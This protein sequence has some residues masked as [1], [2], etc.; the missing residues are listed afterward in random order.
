MSPQGADGIANLNGSPLFIGFR[1]PS[2]GP[3][4]NAAE[5][6]AKDVLNSNQQA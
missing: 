4:S 1:H 5:S 2:G 3:P 6:P